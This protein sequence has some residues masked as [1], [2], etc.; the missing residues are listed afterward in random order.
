MLS[1]A[2]FAQAVVCLTVLLQRCDCRYFSMLAIILQ[3]YLLYWCKS[4]VQILMQVTAGMQTL[5]ACV[6]CSIRC[7]L[8]PCFTDT[9]VPRCTLCL[10]QKHQALRRAW[11]KSTKHAHVARMRAMLN[12]VL[13]ICFTDTEV[14]ILTPKT[15]LAVRG[16]LSR[17]TCSVQKCV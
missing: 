15:L 9:K 10:V 17:R 14:S 4:K 2:L 1:N 6:R 8:F 3:K 7:V 16:R 12:K 13:C 5:R 11:C